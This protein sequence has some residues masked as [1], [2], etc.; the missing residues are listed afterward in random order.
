[1]SAPSAHL[2]MEDPDAS[3]LEGLRAQLADAT[4]RLRRQQSGQRKLALLAARTDNAVLVTDAQGRVEWINHSFTRT[5]G[6]TLHEVA[7]RDAESLLLGPDTDPAQRSRLRDCFARGEAFCAE[8]VNRRKDGRRFRASMEVQPI[9]DDAGL[10]THFLALERDITELRQAYERRTLQYEISRTLASAEDLATGVRGALHA[11]VTHLGWR[12]AALWRVEPGRQHLRL[13]EAVHDPGTDLQ[14]FHD[15]TQRRRF[16]WGDDLPGRVWATYHP[17]WIPDL[18]REVALPRSE[19]AT[20]AGLRTCLA[21]PISCGGRVWGILECFGGAMEEP[22]TDLLHL[23]ESVSSQL[24][25][26]AERTEAR[27]ELELQK[28]LFERV[29]LEAPVAIAILDDLE[30]VRAVNQEFTRLFG[31]TAEEITGDLINSHLVPPS[32]T[33]RAEAATQELLQ[34]HRVAYEAARTDN[35]GVLHHVHVAQQPVQLSSSHPGICA[36]FI[37]LTGRTNAEEALRQSE[38]RLRETTSLQQAILDGAGCGILSTDRAGTILTSNVGAGRILGVTL[39]PAT[40]AP[41]LLA[42]FPAAA[43]ESR[44]RE[45]TAALG[46]PVDAGLESVTALVAPGRTD[47]REWTCAHVDG[48]QLPALISVSGRY[49]EQGALQGYLFVV[50]DISERHQAAQELVRAK[51]AAESANRAKGDFLATVSHEIR[52]PMNGILG[53]SSLLLETRL[54]SH[55][56]EMLEAMRNSAEALMSLINEILDFTKI[57]ARRVDL[58]VEEFDLDTTVD[59]VVD[60]LAHDAQRRGLQLAVI[61]DP[62]TPRRLRTDPIRLRQI[63]LN[64]LGNA[65][66]FTLEGEIL[67]SVEVTAT[68]LRFAVRDTGIGLSPEQ[69]TRLFQPFTQADSSTTRRFGGS[70]LG[71]AICKRVVE[72]MGG[73][74]GVESGRGAGSTFWFTVPCALQPETPPSSALRVLVADDHPTTRHGIRAALAAIGIQPI[75]ASDEDQLV[76]HLSSH[77]IAFDLVIVDRILLGRAGLQALQSVARDRHP[78]PRIALT[79][80]VI[81]AQERTT[82]VTPSDVFLTKP[83]KRSSVARLVQELSAQRTTHGELTAP[84]PPIAADP[85]PPLRVLVAE[86]N[87]VNARLAL[88]MLQKLGCR[89]EIASDGRLAVAALR[90]HAFDVVLMDCHMPDLDGYQASRAIRELERLDPQRPRIP[91]IAMTAAAMPGE[92]ERCFESGMDDHL[93]KPVRLGVLRDAL[94]TH[95][96]GDSKRP[97]VQDPTLG[98]RASLGTLATEL[99]NDAAL[100]LAQAFLLDTPGRIDELRGLAGQ[101]DQPLLQRAA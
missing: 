14:G 38:S 63:L 78:A 3:N 83:V 61:L 90:E 30:R 91:I 46:R 34:G 98:V 29:F 15:D 26:F 75:L 5:T 60:L 77:P 85:L 72:L 76:D 48:R 31:F 92:R 6:Y 23:F 82:V 40:A 95:C 42:F 88:M 24:L 64:L 94:R 36:H 62:R 96:T 56:R 81:D 27:R 49:D 8:S 33:S 20:A 69:Q 74:I 13:E 65:I 68:G 100:E 89:A 54:E 70:G 41:S 21:V 16:G 32:G 57:E 87:E 47:E 58:V 66:K 19:I 93:T 10:V 59:A 28:T 18:A 39:D 101:Q 79:G 53:M 51:E 43:R 52:T 11:V 17:V 35:Q 99:G 50:V 55:Q 45:L 22:D 67:L 86:D 1:M 37:D 2:P 7:G 73:E 71:L 25:Q 4:A 97:A 12:F 80:T 44:A 9:R 84:T